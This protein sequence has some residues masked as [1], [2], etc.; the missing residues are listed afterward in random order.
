M[1]EE[2]VDFDDNEEDVQICREPE[3][4]EVKYG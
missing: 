4:K 2:D 3:E 1:E